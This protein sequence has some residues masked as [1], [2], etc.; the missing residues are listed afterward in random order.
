MPY[1][2]VTLFALSLAALAVM[3]ISACSQQGSNTNLAAQPAPT[4][5]PAPSG[6]GPAAALLPEENRIIDIVKRVSPA[7][8]AVNNYGPNGE[9]VGLGSGFI[10]TP[11]GEILTNNH[12]IQGAS[13]LT[14]TM[15]NGEEV[16]ARSLGGTPLSDLAIVK[17]D[18]TNLPVA[19]LGDSDA[20]QVGQIAIAIGS[21]YGF[22]STVTVGVVSALGRT[23]PGGGSAL[24]ELIQTDARIYPGN[25]GGPLVD[26]AG[27]VIGINAAVVGGQAGVLGFALPINTA[28]AIMEEV[29]RTGRVIT[30]W[31]GISYGEITPEVAQV[32][33]LP[34]TKGVIVA[35]VQRGG[36][37]ARAGLQ[38]KDI[39]TRANGKA[40]ENG[41]DLQKVIRDLRVGDKLTLR[42]LRN[43][44]QRSITVTVGEMPASMR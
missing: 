16:P 24:T 25:S 34:V 22:E 4:A 7:V 39:I 6:R 33:D 13:K 3:M 42:I 21:P 11:D 8:L 27:Q 15:A 29:R 20:L 10:V 5:Q 28:R 17:I 2:R 14:V 36:P 44:Q 43:G 38:R 35:D 23:I 19:P 31:I 18:R 40:I 9:Q 26:S 1:R 30:P 12:V 41:G 37:A 32:F